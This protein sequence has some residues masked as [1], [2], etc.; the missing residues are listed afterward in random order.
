LKAAKTNPA[1][2]KTTADIQRSLA[3]KRSDIRVPA[4]HCP[5]AAPAR[6]GPHRL[7]RAQRRQPQ[8]PASGTFRP[9]CGGQRIEGDT[10][11]AGCNARGG[12]IK[13]MRRPT[14]PACLRRQAAA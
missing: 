6:R 12:R 1:A 5:L 11:A 3:C 13:E 10:H 7:H 8:P 2:V 14:G 4:P 9:A